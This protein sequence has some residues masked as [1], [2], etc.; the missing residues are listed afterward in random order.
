MGGRAL[1]EVKLLGLPLRASPSLPQAAG[2]LL[3]PPTRLLY[4]LLGLSHLL[5]LS[6][7]PIYKGY[8]LLFFLPGP[9]LL[10]ASTSGQKP[11]VGFSSCVLSLWELVKSRLDKGESH[12]LH[13]S[14]AAFPPPCCLS[15]KFSFPWGL[16][17]RNSWPRT[18]KSILLPRRRGARK[19]LGGQKDPDLV[20]IF[21][22]V[23]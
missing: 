19:G 4:F 12:K 23:L 17:S 21:S 16:T 9:L 7:D 6:A 8:K 5:P 20:G 10:A 3:S 18:Q 14:P 11:W 13:S 22:A 15:L 2:L 1:L